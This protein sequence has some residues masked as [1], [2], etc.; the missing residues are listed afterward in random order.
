MHVRVVCMLSCFL[1][2]SAG[3]LEDL[4]KALNQHPGIWDGVPK[5]THTY[6]HNA[7]LHKYILT[8]GHPYDLSASIIGHNRP[9]YSPNHPFDWFQVIQ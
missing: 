2:Y 7:L 4:S 1:S 9:L 5:H 8:I 3:L 6:T